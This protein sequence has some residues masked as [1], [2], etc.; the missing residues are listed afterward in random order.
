LLKDI[1]SL[2]VPRIRR[3]ARADMAAFATANEGLARPLLVRPTGSHGGDDLER[4]DNRAELAAY[5]QRVPADEYYVS[6]FWDYRGTDGLF[7]KYRLIFV[8]CQVFPY[9]LAITRHW[10]A[11]YWRAEMADAMK[12]EEEAFL[13]DFRQA[14]RGPAADA[15]REAA[16]RL[17]LDY[18]GMDCTILPDG[19]V[20]VFEANAAM[21]MHLRESRA[22]FAY[23]TR[24]CRAS[25]RRSAR[26]CCGGSPSI[27]WRARH[28]AAA[29][30]CALVPACWRRAAAIAWRRAARLR[31]TK[32]LRREVT[33]A[34]AA[35]ELRMLRQ[36]S[37]AGRD[38]RHDLQL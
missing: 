16:R 7:R 21:L 22:A 30:R 38:R 6:D 2:V 26:W 25:S 10:L 13:A 24:T 31:S 14:F 37:A 32:A 3:I 4:L 36:G 8:D 5:A 17:E 34:R 27:A 35:P 15:V 23:K 12:R 28:E 33:Y 1:P 20:L 18:A 11:H 29:A 9:H 19:R